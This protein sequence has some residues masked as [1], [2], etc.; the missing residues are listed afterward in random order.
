MS[1][2]PKVTKAVITAAGLGTRF[3]PATAAMPKE[4]LPVL[5]RPIIHHAV[6]EAAAAGIS[7]VII[8]VSDTGAAFKRYFKPDARIEAALK[9]KGKG[10]LLRELHDLTDRVKIRYVRQDA[11][12]GLGHAVL[13]ARRAVGDTP[14][15]VMLPDDLIVGE[16][17]VLKQLT[18]VYDE[19]RGSVVAVKRI[20]IMDTPKYG[21]IDP[22]KL[23]RGLHQVKR[24]VEKPQPLAAPSNLA[25]V[26]RYVLSPGVFDSLERTPQGALGEIQLTDALELTLFRENIYALEFSG[27]R[28]DTGT[29]LGLLKAANALALAREDIG[30]ELREYLKGLELG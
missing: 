2:Q 3:L 5:D 23:S 22:K 28:Y 16:V 6:A 7:E 8:V 9:E 14:F 15:A 21:I 24:L 25:V 19:Y 4:L 17:P 27:V 26:G 1:R 20:N 12:R 13:T 30:P 29:P 18:D 11:P 10:D